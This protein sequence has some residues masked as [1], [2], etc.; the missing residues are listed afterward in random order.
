MIDS[1]LI[2]A[3]T[4][5]SLAVDI[6]NQ[7]TISI[8]LNPFIWNREHT[9]PDAA[10]IQI[11]TENICKQANGRANVCTTHM[12][13]SEDQASQLLSHTP[14][15]SPCRSRH[16]MASH[17]EAQKTCHLH[18]THSFNNMTC[19]L[20]IWGRGK[21]HIWCTLNYR[22]AKRSPKRHSLS[23]FLAPAAAFLAASRSSAAAFSSSVSSPKRSRSSSSW[24]QENK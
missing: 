1:F 19:T 15:A 4:V 9:P 20:T 3:T 14:P 10:A 11:S 18:S 16:P 5:W 6:Y 2:P 7:S 23:F 24:T 12:L 22:T 21:L 17:Q 8:S 13:P